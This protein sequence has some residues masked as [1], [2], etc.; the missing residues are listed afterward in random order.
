VEV[1]TDLVS[2]T[3]LESMALSATGLEEVGSLLAVTC[4]LN[5]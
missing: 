4:G 1:R 2:L 3:L 5:Y